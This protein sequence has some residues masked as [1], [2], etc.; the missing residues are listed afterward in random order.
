MLHNGGVKPPP[1]RSGV[2]RFLCSASG[3]ASRLLVLVTSVV[4]LAGLHNMVT[5]SLVARCMRLGGADGAS[6]GGKILGTAAGA[7]QRRLLGGRRSSTPTPGRAQ[8]VG[9]GDRIGAAEVPQMEEAEVDFLT[10]ATRLSRLSSPD[11]RQLLLDAVSPRAAEDAR[12]S[13]K[14][15]AA[16]L[17]AA[18]V[19]GSQQL[20]DDGRGVPEVE[21]EGGD[22]GGGGASDDLVRYSQQTCYLQTDESEVRMRRR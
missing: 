21:K 15:L 22:G 19:A 7:L 17:A 9:G 2:A 20:S 16:A 3:T 13:A 8:V 1:A 4:F 11:E 10:A 18:A 6:G 5:M 12:Q 14:R